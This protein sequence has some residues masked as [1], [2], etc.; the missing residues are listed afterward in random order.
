MNNEIV[1]LTEKAKTEFQQ[2][3][4]AEAAADF[5]GCLDLLTQE[6]DPLEIA[7]M[8]NNL[9]VSLLRNSDPTAALDAVLGTE[10]VFSRA[11]DLQRQGIAQANLGTIYEALKSYD[12]AAVSYQNSIESFKQSGDKKLRSITL[13]YLSNLQLKTGKQYNAVATLQASYAEKPEASLK[14]KFFASA[15]GKVINKLLGH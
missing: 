11:S 8:R 6:N 5:Q 15:L 13:R 2:N 12:L 3:K 9:G 7:E 14:D 1:S 4:F 10:D